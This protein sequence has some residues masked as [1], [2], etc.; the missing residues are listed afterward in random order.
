MDSE[1]NTGEPNAPDVEVD[2]AMVRRYIS[3]R[4]FG[5]MIALLHIWMH[6]LLAIASHDFHFSRT[7]LVC[8]REGTW[9]V[10]I[11]V[12]TD[13]L[14][15]EMALYQESMGEEALSPLWLGDEREHPKAEKWAGDVVEDAWTLEVNDREVPCTYLGMEVDYD[16]TYLY[17]ES[18]PTEFAHVIRISNALFFD[19]FDDQV[20]EVHVE[21]NATEKRE[22]LTREMPN[23]TYTP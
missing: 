17:L 2:C 7:D 20:N 18:A 3:V 22:L 6:A 14:E 4:N 9:Q 21:F 1:V 10:T 12:F 8:S 23:W 15:R 19:Q 5:S 13:D 16:V 11:R